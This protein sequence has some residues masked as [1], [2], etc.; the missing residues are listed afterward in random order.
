MGKR[1]VSVDLIHEVERKRGASYDGCFQGADSQLWLNYPICISEACGDGVSSA[2]RFSPREAFSRLLYH[3][4]TNDH[5]IAT[6]TKLHLVSK[7]SFT[8]RTDLQRKAGKDAKQQGFVYE[9]ILLRL[10]VSKIGAE[11]FVGN[12]ACASVVEFLELKVSREANDELRDGV[13]QTG[14]QVG[15]A[16]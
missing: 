2:R 6:S 10:F 4:D 12:G 11:R 9:S 3:T 16:V 1:I 13:L 15:F 7:P 14:D 8:E 5:E